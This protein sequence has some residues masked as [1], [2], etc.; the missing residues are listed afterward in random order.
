MYIEIQNGEL[1]SL[2]QEIIQL[3]PTAIDLYGKG[4]GEVLR[5]AFRESDGGDKEHNCSEMC[6]PELCPAFIL[7][8]SRCQVPLCCISKPAN[9]Q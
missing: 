5:S 7:T 2:P 9:P 6:Q 3:F 1:R 4:K 8:I